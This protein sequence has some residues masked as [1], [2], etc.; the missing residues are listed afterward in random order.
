MVKP[1]G[2][3][4]KNGLTAIANQ[5]LSRPAIAGRSDP[6][7]LN[8]DYFELLEI[9][10]KYKFEVGPCFAYTPFLF[11]KQGNSHRYRNTP[12][13]LVEP[14]KAPSERE[15]HPCLAALIDGL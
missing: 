11:R 7:V 12:I 13:P 2:P 15:N 3:M 5:L 6:L 14:K 9:T 8:H 4:K 10:S 1:T